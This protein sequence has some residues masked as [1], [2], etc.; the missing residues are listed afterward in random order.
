MRAHTPPPQCSRLVPIPG[1]CSVLLSP[2]FDAK[3]SLPSRNTLEQ[4]LPGLLGPIPPRGATPNPQGSA[5][6]PL[7]CLH[8]GPQSLEQDPRPRSYGA[9]G[10]SSPQCPLPL[11][12]SGQT[13]ASQARKPGASPTAHG[14]ATQGSLIYPLGGAAS[15]GRFALETVP[16]EARPSPGLSTLCLSPAESKI[17]LTASLERMMQAILEEVLTGQRWSQMP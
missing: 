15:S 13:R 16:G 4:G 14:L 6:G 1:T 9:R 7:S 8:L 12:P 5:P 17:S 2:L 3:T 10:Q 11:L